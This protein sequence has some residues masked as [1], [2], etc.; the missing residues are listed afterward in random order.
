MINIGVK[1]WSNVDIGF[2]KIINIER[3]GNSNERKLEKY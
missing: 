3:K 1:K 2:K